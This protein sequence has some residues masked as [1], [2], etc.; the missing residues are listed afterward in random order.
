MKKMIS[1]FTLVFAAAVF[2]SGCGQGSGDPVGPRATPE[3]SIASGGAGGSDSPARVGASD[4][5][6][7]SSD[8]GILS[9]HIGDGKPLMPSGTRGLVITIDEASVYESEKGWIALPLA[10]SPLP[11]DLLHFTEGR[12]YPF[13]PNSRVPPGKYSRVRIGISKAVIRTNRGVLEINVPP[14]SMKPDLD[15]P[16]AVKGGDWISLTVDFDLGRSLIDRGSNYFTL[17]PVLRI[18]PTQKA[19]A[20]EGNI[21]GSTFGITADDPYADRRALVEV[22]WDRNSNGRPD[23][24]ELHTKINVEN[25]TDPAPFRIHW[26]A[27]ERNYIVSVRVEGKEVYREVVEGKNLPA[28]NVWALNKGKPI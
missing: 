8:A 7:G 3:T 23:G 5:L 21:E 1:Y 28:G 19:A 17:D 26:L 20:I 10:R 14:Y 16:F 6:A 2:A 24:D 18:V 11:V 13:V 27:P 9:L 12:T 15:F 22:Y 25:W 4:S